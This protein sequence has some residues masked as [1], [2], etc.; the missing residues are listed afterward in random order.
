MGSRHCAAPGPSDSLGVMLSIAESPKVATRGLATQVGLP[1]R[2]GILGYV[3]AVL[4]LRMRE[5]QPGS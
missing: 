1:A 2:G 4:G 3:L 5:A